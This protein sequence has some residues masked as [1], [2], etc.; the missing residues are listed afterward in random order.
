MKR[1]C[2]IA[3]L[4]LAL[5]IAVCVVGTLAGGTWNLSLSSPF[6]FSSSSDSGSATEVDLD[7]TDS[8]SRLSL[9]LDDAVVSIQTGDVWSLTSTRDGRGLTISN[10]DTTLAIKQKQLG[11]WSKSPQLVLTIPSDVTL[12]RI[13]GELDAVVLSTSGTISA[14]KVS[15]EADGATM[16]IEDLDADSLDLDCDGATATLSARLRNDSTID[17]D[18]GVITLTLLDG[19]TISDVDT[20][21]DLGTFSING[22]NYGSGLSGT[23]E[24]KI[25]SGKA[26]GTLSI[27]CDAGN[28]SLQTP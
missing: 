23:I 18:A 1:L 2:Q 20:K 3:C 21:F 25:G 4:L 15:L 12:E 8:I 9:D 5:G 27:D 14:K 19:S 10:D 17:C 22:K 6:S 26:G 7:D 11:K 13:D 16:T 28:I 24:K